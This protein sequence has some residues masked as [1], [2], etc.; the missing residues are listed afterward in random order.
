MIIIDG[1]YREGGGQILRSSLTLSVITGQ[2]IE[3]RNIRARRPRPGL[4]PQHL[5][6]VKAAA[7]ICGAQLEGAE[8]GSQ[9]L[10][11]IPDKVK[12]GHY[13]FTIGTAGSVMLV[14]QTVL[15]PL[16]LSQ[17]VSEVTLVGG[18]HVPWS[19]C[20]HYID[21]V[22]RPAISAMGISF[23]MELERWG[24]YPK[25]GGI[26]RT[27]ILPSKRLS[28]FK[29]AFQREERIRVKAISATARLPDHVRKRQSA[30]V[31]SALEGRAVKVEIKELEGSALCPGSLLFCWISGQGRYGGFTGLGAR[32]KPAEKVADEAVS[33]LLS[34]LDSDAACDKYL[35]DQILLPAMLAGGESHWTTDSISNHFHTNVWVT[36]CF[37]LGKVE[38]LEEDEEFSLIKCHGGN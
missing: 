2:A 28:P 34:F 33:R 9:H 29:P 23:K 7:S 32:G 10:I 20:F 13:S 4:C 25:G 16:A 14:F 19:P 1:S 27:R 18:T 15:L 17:S 6:C 11:F 37:G 31:K 22:F 30:R 36:E 21:L 12:P 3:I 5:T 26:V 24:Y 35:S 38:M 8:F